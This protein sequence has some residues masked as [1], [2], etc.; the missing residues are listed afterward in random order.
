L[1]KNHEIQD[2]KLFYDQIEGDLSEMIVFD[3]NPQ[4]VV[5]QT[6]LVPQKV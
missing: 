5:Y 3:W 4:S 1:Q 6:L 2:I